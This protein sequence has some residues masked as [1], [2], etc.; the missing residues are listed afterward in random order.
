MSDIIKAVVYA[1]YSSYNQTEQS[2]EGQ[3]H[4]AHEFAAR[5]NMV[6]VHEYIDRAQSGTKDNRTAFQEMIKDAEKETF[7]VVIVWKLDRFAR[8]RYDS[9][10]YKARLK[11]SGVRVVSVMERIEDNPEGIILEGMLESMAEYYS[12]NLSENVKRGLRETISKGLFYGGPTPFG[13]RKEGQRLV[14]DPVDAPIMREIFERYAGGEPARSITKDL[15]S[16]GLPVQSRSAIARQMASTVY[17][18][19]REINGQI[20]SIAEPLID[21]TTFDRA[22]MHLAANRQRSGSANAVE[23]YPLSGKLVCGHCGQRM[24]GSVVTSGGKR[25]AYYGCRSHKNG[26]G[27][28]KKLEPRDR[29]DEYVTEQTVLHILEPDVIAQISADVACSFADTF[30]A[31]QIAAKSAQIARLGTII[32][33]LVDSIGEAPK[34]AR[35]RIFE[36]IETLTAQRTDMEA[37]LASMQS[38]AAVDIKKDDVAEWLRSFAGGDPKSKDY[39][40]KVIDSFISHVIITN[41]S[42][43][44]FYNVRG[45]DKISPAAASEVLSEFCESAHTPQGLR[46]IT[47]TVYL[48][49]GIPGLIITR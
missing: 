39:Q 33:N 40:T 29:L 24:H 19:Y 31:A 46:Q 2:I 47:K 8:N 12:A 4:D 38:A 3:L 44:V 13:Y 18:G 9:A 43:A 16:R 17:L 34:T 26:D 32:D 42:I 30:G 49:A 7:E 48:Y 20:V 10:I 37:D 25:Y 1:R 5:E 35:K 21:K 6:I 45:V 22:A 27:C 41:D 28:G 14:L 11:K 15:K 36:R 23:S